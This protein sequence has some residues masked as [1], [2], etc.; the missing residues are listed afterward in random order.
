MFPHFCLRLHEWLSRVGG[1]TSILP[2]D[3]VTTRSCFTN[4]RRTLH[5]EIRTM[6]RHDRPVSDEEFEQMDE[7]IA[8]HFEQ[9]RAALEDALDG[10]DEA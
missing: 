3:V 10:E 7:R 9:V 8:E 5:Q 2:A 1:L 4:E 6:A